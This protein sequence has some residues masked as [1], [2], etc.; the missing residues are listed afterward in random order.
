[1]GRQSSKLFVGKDVHKE[2]K[3][4]AHLSFAYTISSR[5]PTVLSA[6]AT[7]RYQAALAAR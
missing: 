1:M 7:Y 6:A 5:W 4:T 3:A 2:C